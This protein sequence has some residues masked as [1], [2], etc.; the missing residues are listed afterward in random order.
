MTKLGKI[1]W[2]IIIL[3]FFSYLTYTHFYP[4][5]LPE[6]CIP[7]GSYSGNCPPPIECYPFPCLIINN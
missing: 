2:F 3:V 7:D 5:P 6:K 1:L 4:A